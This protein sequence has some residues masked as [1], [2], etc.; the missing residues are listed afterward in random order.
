MC[1]CVKKKMCFYLF[2]VSK[3]FHKVNFCKNAQKIP[4]FLVR[5]SG[6]FMRFHLEKGRLF[7]REKVLNQRN[8]TF[9]Q[10][11]IGHLRVFCLVFGI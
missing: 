9:E 5:N 7:C 4:N 8:S 2:G 11:Q 3:V 10:G 1:L 6:F